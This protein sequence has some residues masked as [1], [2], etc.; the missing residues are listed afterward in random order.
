MVEL[1]SVKS[2]LIRADIQSK[3]Y[4]GYGTSMK[5]V[6]ETRKLKKGNTQEIHRG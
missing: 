3:M 1:D 4:L 6:Q 5:K 2:E